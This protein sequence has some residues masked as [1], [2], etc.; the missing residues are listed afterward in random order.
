MDIL[1]ERLEI[2]PLDESLL[3][4]SDE[5]NSSDGKIADDSSSQGQEDTGAETGQ[6]TTDLQNQDSENNNS[7]NNEAV[8]SSIS[9]VQ[10]NNQ[11]ETNQTTTDF[12]NKNNN[13]KISNTTNNLQNDYVVVYSKETQ[14]F[15]VY[16]VKEILST[17]ENIISENKKI[18]ILKSNN[19]AIDSET[20]KISEK[21][22]DN[23]K[24][25][26]PFIIIIV[27][28]FVLLIYISLNK[29]SKKKK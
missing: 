12:Q 19:V 4:K 20:L 6:N 26:I 15:E 7:S 18:D 13:D 5:N 8:D 10:D 3:E 29:T 27:V 25:T 16:K 21:I 14:N 22:K 9:Q 1:K 2:V 24:G 28:I 11:D 23:A 17:K